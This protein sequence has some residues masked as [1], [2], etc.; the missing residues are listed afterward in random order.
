MLKLF[1]QRFLSA[2]PGV[3]HYACHSHHYWPDVTR[4][5]MLKYWD[6][7]AKWVDDKWD[8]MFGE[9]V[10]AVQRQISRVLNL[11][12]PQ[13]IVFA[14]NT[15]ELLFRLLS[16]FDWSKPLKVLT[17][18]S[19]FHSFNRQIRRLNELANVEVVMVPTEPFADVQQRLVTAASALQPDLVFVS[20][21]FFNSGV[22][23]GRL[24]PLVTALEQCC[25]ATIAI[26][27]YHAF[28]ALPT[29]LSILEGRIFYLA[30]SYKYAQGGEGCCFMVVPSTTAFRPLYTGWFAEFGA[31]SGERHHQVQ[32][33][34]D[35]YRFAGATMD[36]SAMYRLRSVLS[37]YEEK[38]IG[39]W[40]IHQYVQR[41][42]SKFLQEL[43]RYSHPWLNEHNLLRNGDAEH[44]HFLTF[45]GPS[46]D[47]VAELAQ[48]LKRRAIHTDY[49]GDRLRFGFAPYL[50]LDDIDL[51]AL[52]E[53]RS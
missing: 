8:H 48:G 49:R 22:C 24:D 35:G 4:D 12:T 33:A 51:S 21:V 6:D 18:D 2:N 53:L 28:M 7:S 29:D 11:K 40:H 46:A 20:Q 26:D 10:P 43:A 47:A 23:V 32:Y 44:G 15:H 5:A 52:R 41:L 45:R 19:E 30:G 16:C 9:T 1:Y 37:L 34:S 38:A 27:G 39:V 13:Q 17:T 42:Q 3:Q 36:L 50:E 14:P 25:Q 31:L